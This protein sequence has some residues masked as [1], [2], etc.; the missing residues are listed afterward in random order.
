MLKETW[1]DIISLHLSNDFVLGYSIYN[2]GL[3]FGFKMIIFQLILLS[4]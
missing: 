3:Q 2:I 1:N 4:H